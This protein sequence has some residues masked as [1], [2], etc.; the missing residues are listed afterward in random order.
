MSV[1]KF[2]LQLNQL[3]EGEHGF[4]VMSWFC[5]QSYVVLQQLRCT[6]P[7]LTLYKPTSSKQVVSK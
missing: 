5:W 4:S 6:I 3:H 2:V 7:L 1:S